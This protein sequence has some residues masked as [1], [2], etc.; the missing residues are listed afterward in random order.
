MTDRMPFGA[1]FGVDDIGAAAASEPSPKKSGP[2]SHFVIWAASR[3]VKGR[4]R[5]VT[6]MED[7]DEEEESLSMVPEAMAFV[8][9]RWTRPRSIAEVCVVCEKGRARGRI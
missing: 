7:A 8:L 4:T 9:V 6:A 2:S 5:T 1:S 3:M